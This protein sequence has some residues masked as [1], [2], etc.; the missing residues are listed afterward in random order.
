MELSKQSKNKVARSNRC[1]NLFA[2]E[3]PRASSCR[4]M[5]VT[6]RVTSPLDKCQFGGTSRCRATTS[7]WRNSDQYSCIFDVTFTQ[8][9]FNFYWH[10]VRLL[11]HGE[12]HS[13]SIQGQSLTCPSF[14]F[15]GCIREKTMI[16]SISLITAIF[17]LYLLV[18]AAQEVCSASASPASVAVAH[19]HIT[20]FLDSADNEGKFH[21]QGW[22][23]HTM[24]LVREADRLNKLARSLQDSSSDKD[25]PALTEAVDYVVGFNM[26]G[27][28]KIENDLFFPWVRK[29]VSEVNESRVVTAFGTLMD[30]LECERQAIAEL[31]A[32]L[33][34]RM[35]VLLSRS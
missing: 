13:S 22:R 11:H 26:K 30:Q 8:K 9:L 27:L 3:V 12:G 7:I 25:L 19:E 4:T 17:W 33:V 16:R 35:Y 24:S 14:F 6:E 34:S 28:H 23:W 1:D 29:K 15:S 10:P 32:S 2:D 18:V 20:R 5:D 21:V 31:G